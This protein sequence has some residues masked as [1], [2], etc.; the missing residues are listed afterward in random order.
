MKEL[1]DDP[2]IQNCLCIGGALL[3]AMICAGFYC[4]A[5]AKWDA[6]S[7]NSERDLPYEPEGDD[8]P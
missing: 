8:A 1:L 2:F 4:L 7:R 5:V 3:F 6:D